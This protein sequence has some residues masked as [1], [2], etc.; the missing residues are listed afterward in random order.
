MK[1]TISKKCDKI[2]EK[3]LQI[4]KD[5]IIKEIN[6]ISIILFGGFGKGEGT[7]QKQGNKIIPLNDYD[8]YLITKNKLNENKLNELGMKCSKAIGKGGLEYSSHPTEKY[9][10]NKFFH[11]DIRCIS[12]KDLKKLLPTQRTYELKSSKIIYGENI[13]HKI[14][15]VVVPVSDGIRLLFNKMHH[16]LLSRDTDKKFKLMHISK[17]FL[18]CCTALLI[19]E[20]KMRPTYRERNLV[21][22][23]TNFPRELKKR[24][25]WATKMKTNPNFNVKN[26]SKLWNEARDWVFYSLKYILSDRLK[27]REDVANYVY[28]KLPYTYFT[29]YT[30]NKYL[31][32]LQYYLN[33]L[34]FIR[35]I[36]NRKFLIRPLL[37]WRDVGL[38][39]S[40]PIM[41][42]IYNDK[43]NSRIY[44]K[45]I[46]GKTEPLKERILSLYGLYY[47]QKLI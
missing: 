44:L 15:E 7:I 43:E 36:K 32:P 41:F 19:Y 18:D 21:F 42:Y 16:L 34:Y 13:L 11:V 37:S 26:I 47:E 27:T 12:Y 1:Y 6:P 38:K 8:I 9:D 35:G 40:I 20:N 5:I 4:V 2:V 3:E 23:K 33:I 29:P 46:T 31:F 28:K 14:P 17:A 24:V 25:K 22:Q 30:K 39:L 45:K 10:E